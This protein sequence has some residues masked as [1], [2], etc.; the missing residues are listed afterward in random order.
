MQNYWLNTLDNVIPKKYG[1]LVKR[2]SRLCFKG[3]NITLQL[4]LV[5]ET[6]SVIF[7][8]PAKVNGASM[9]PTLNAEEPEDKDNGTLY[10]HPGHSEITN[11]WVFVN[12]WSMRKPNQQRHI[13]AGDIVVFVSPKDENDAVIKRV[14][15]TEHQIIQTRK[16]GSES[17]RSGG[18]VVVIPAGHC[19]VEG[20]NQKTS[21]DS[22]KYGP[23]S[24][25][26]IFG[27][28]NWVIY[29]FHRIRK[30]TF[31]SHGQSE[32]TQVIGS[33]GVPRNYI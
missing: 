10:T 24:Y 6:F 9:S 31:T 32:S 5:Y 2:G 1:R 29:P 19:W 3:V 13:Q 20:D 4:Y 11:E 7:G 17:W 12:R 16:K 25:G 15:A 21:V 22:R 23:V 30:L 8:Y 33:E 18:D 14:I 26:L 27:K 28:V